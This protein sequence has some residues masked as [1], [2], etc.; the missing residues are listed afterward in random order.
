MLQ[1]L[2]HFA[3]WEIEH[4]AEQLGRVLG[5]PTFAD[6]QFVV[7]D[8]VIFAHKAMIGTV[9]VAALRVPVR[10]CVCVCVWV[11]RVRDADH[12]GGMRRAG[13]A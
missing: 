11:Q 9:G 6:V 4:E 13:A 12:W 7:Q 3:E 8:A 5:D 10:L 2:D 1:N